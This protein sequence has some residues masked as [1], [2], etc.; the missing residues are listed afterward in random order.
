M[1]L[2]AVGMLNLVAGASQMVDLGAS[3]ERFSYQTQAYIVASGAPCTIHA[4]LDYRDVAGGGAATTS[5]PAVCGVAPYGL[6]P[7]RQITPG[8]GLGQLH[9]YLHLISAV[10]CRA[11]VSRWALP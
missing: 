5:D 6:Q 10:N 11:V 4:R 7:G 1:R 8:A 2:E 9:R 3:C